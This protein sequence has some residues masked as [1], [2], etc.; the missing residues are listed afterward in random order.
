MGQFFTKI[1][2]VTFEN[3]QRTIMRLF[4]EG[5][6]EIGTELKLIRDENNPYDKN[7]IGVFSMSGLQLGFIPRNTAAQM[8]A[9][10]DNGVRYRAFIHNISEGGADLNYGI[11]LLIKY[12][13]SQS[14]YPHTQASHSYTEP[15][16]S[17]RTGGKHLTPS[18][19]ETGYFS[20][21]RDDPEDDPYY[22]PDADA[23]D[24]YPFYVE[25]KNDEYYSPDADAEDDYP[26]FVERDHDEDESDEN[27]DIIDY[28]SIDSSGRDMFPSGEEGYAMYQEWLDDLDD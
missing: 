7:A 21:G 22:F 9:D 12:D 14:F 1:A 6:L 10:M 5:E 17:Q 16:L 24:D 18:F 4:N 26:F 8:A 2:G 28:A 13:E 3:R 11:N 27:Y 20:S 25:K 15:P 23:E 19:Y